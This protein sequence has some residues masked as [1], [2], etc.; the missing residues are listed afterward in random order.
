M[1]SIAIVRAGLVAGLV[2][3]LRERLVED[4]VDERRLARAADAGD[5]GQHAERNLDVDVL[6]VVLARAADDEL[7]LQLPAAAPRGVGIDRAPVRYAPVSDPA[8]V[9]DGCVHQLRRRALED[10]VAAVLAGAGAEI[11]HV[12]GGADR[13]L[14]VLDDDHGVA[15][16]A[17]PRQRRRAACGC[18]AGAG[19]STARRARR[20]RRSGSRRSA[21]PA[22]CA[23]LRRPTASRRCGR[24]SGSRRRRRSESAAAPESRAGSARR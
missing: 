20:A 13:L 7:A 2:E 4:V 9:C 12:V 15:E 24:A 18:R 10:H 19:R 11:D 23:G 8:S 3:R 16:I 6:Q 14:V 1:P 22:G 21:S 5:R 17:Q